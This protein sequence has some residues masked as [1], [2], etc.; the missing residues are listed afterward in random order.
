MT[1]L[2]EQNR[3]SSQTF[4]A[5]TGAFTPAELDRIVAHGD[6]LATDKATLL[7]RPED[8]SA[9][10]IRITQTAWVQPTP[11]TQWLYDRLQQTIRALNERTYKYDLTG[12][13]EPLQYT[14][15]HGHEGGHYGWH[16]DHGPL[17]VQRKFSISVQLSDSSDYEGCDLEFQ[18]GNRIETA[19]RTKGAI[20]GFPSYVLHRV[21]PCTKGTR[22]A[23]VAWTTGPKLR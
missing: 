3:L 8:V 23:L 18:A 6:G 10:T 5:W 21:T 9:D 4:N 15:Y 11:E 14:V 22:K 1:T 16:V 20:I 19:P 17:K 2:L 7:T 13:S 12:F